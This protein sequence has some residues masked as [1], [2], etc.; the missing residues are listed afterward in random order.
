MHRVKKKKKR[1]KSG[2]I[3]LSV[4]V[5]ICSENVPGATF[6]GRCLWTI[7]AVHRREEEG[8]AEEIITVGLIQALSGK[9]VR[10]GSATCILGYVMFD[11]MGKQTFHPP[12]IGLQTA[13]GVFSLD[14]VT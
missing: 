2:E 11:F 1:K 8:R 6:L 13:L 14:S 7:A 3:R 5:F 10:R 4:S 9:T 12:R